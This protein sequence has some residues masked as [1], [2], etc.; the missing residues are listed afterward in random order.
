MAVDI[1]T[2]QKIVQRRWQISP[3]LQ[4]WQ[5]QIVDDL[6]SRLKHYDELIWVLSSGTKSL[7]TVKAIGLSK[8]ALLCAAEGANK[9]L[10]SNKNDRW[11]VAIP[12]YHVGGLAIYARSYLS[13]AKVFRFKGR[14]SAPRFV[15]A[16]KDDRITLT[17]LVPTQIF[18]L[19]ECGLKAPP[20]L[21]AVVV[22]G[23]NLAENIYLSARRLGW[24]LLPS[25]GMTEA[26]SQVAT[27]PLD[28][29]ETS[30]VF[31]A[32]ALLPHIR[33]ELSGS[34][35]IRIH[36]R[37][38]CSCV[39]ILGTES[40]FSLEDPRRADFLLSEDL[41]EWVESG[42]SLKI[43]G[44]RDSVVKV[45][46]VLVSLLEVEQEA[47]RYFHQNGW[48]ET[49][50]V[51]ATP[52]DRLG[53]KLILISDSQKSLKEW[54]H[55]MDSYNRTV[56]GPRRLRAL[57]WVPKIPRTDLMKVKQVELSRLFGA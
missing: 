49:F 50:T 42:R 37:A 35:R 33:V 46:G 28:S 38:L 40:A 32:L 12:D 19:V 39:A 21:R 2:W 31:P 6:Q 53:A 55:W 9:H 11:L 29:L 41:A 36:S 8:E 54:E 22:G 17:S 51:I 13:G 10:K 44:R 24:P 30:E 27:A 18:D 16:L 43:L 3:D 34:G 26:G 52:H 15:Q 56:V 25:Y 4:P 7:N 47:I 57:A 45:L 23:G 20:S 48:R 1:L 14:W 5:K